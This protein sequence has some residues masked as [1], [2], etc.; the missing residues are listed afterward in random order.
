MKNRTYMLWFLRFAFFGSMALWLHSAPTEPTAAT[1]PTVTSVHKLPYKVTQCEDPALSPSERAG[2]KIWFYA[3]AGNGR[4]HA[5]VLP[6]R[7]PVLLDW[8][9]VLRSDQRDERFHSWGVINDPECCTPGKP[10][11]PRKKLEE[12]FGMD[13]CPGDDELL[14]YVGRQGY[15]DPACD[16]EDSPADANDVHKGQRESS[17]ALEFG[18]SSGAMGIRKF[19]NPRFDLE[20]WKKV[21]GGDLTTWKGF[22]DNTVQPPTFYSRLRDASIEPPFYF[23][24]SCGACHIAFDPTNPPKDPSHPAPENLKGVV[25]NQYTNITAIMSSGEPPN[26]PLWRIFNYVRSGTVD[27][28]AFPHDFDGNA[29]T[30]NGIFNLN[31]RPT[32]PDEELTKWF[33]TDHCDSGADEKVCWCQPGANNKCWERRA[34]NDS[35]RKNDADPVMHILKG[36]ED[37]VGVLEAVQ[38]VYINIG[39]CSETCWENHLVNFFVLDPNDRGYGQTPFSIGQCRRDCP[40]F[41]AI[42][43]RLPDIAHFLLAQRPADLY[44]ARHLK[45]REELI[46]QLDKEFGSGSVLKGKEVFANNCAKCHSSQQPDKNGNFSNVDFWAT[47]KN[48]ERIDFLSNDVAYPMATIG[49][50]PGRA[51]HSNHMKGHVWEEYGSDTLRNRAKADDL[52]PPAPPEA[53]SGPDG[54]GY[55]RPASLLSLWATAPYMHNN[56]L[57]PEVCGRKPDNKSD[58]EQKAE[59]IFYESTYDP[60]YVD[61]NGKPSP[62]PPE[63]RLFD[64]ITS[65]DGRYKLFKD[66]VAELLTPPDERPKKVTRLHDDILVEVGPAIWDP[67]HKQKLQFKLMIP[68]G[69]PQME[70]GNLLYKKLIADMVLSQKDPDALRKKLG[71]DAD[72]AEVGALLKEFIANASDAGEGGI[73]PFAVL[74]PHEKLLTKY[75]MTNHEFRDNIGHAFG[76]DLS[77]ADKKALTAFLATL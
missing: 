48:G 44:V 54:R 72:A 28:S 57:G 75:Y 70:V 1:A 73:T 23:G 46:A 47:D 25:G 64:S 22:D 50:N 38:R 77:P 32:F 13:Y 76:T 27:T 39:S 65:V 3:T 67:I 19:P 20:K 59:N 60:P 34:K 17:C 51:L 6:Q 62:T 8:Y 55:Y 49:T 66:S 58:K 42:E 71:N 15:R 40:N 30:P 24:M 5:Y 74:T 26:G 36:A 11:C 14:Q 16:F 37:S 2:C 29:G 4:F 31:K 69:T 7:L 63:C 18:T 12:T 21:N 10:G 68:K 9:R 35:D 43:D 41:R 61:E 53:G 52:P 56:A 45:S 33:K